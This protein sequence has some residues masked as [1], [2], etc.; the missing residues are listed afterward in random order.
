[1]VR[2][3]RV[4]WRLPVSTSTYRNLYPVYTPP[5]GV[6]SS[7]NHLDT[8]RPAYSQGLDARFGAHVLTEIDSTTGRKRT[9][10]PGPQLRT[11]VGAPR[12]GQIMGP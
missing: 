1:M 4:Y 2:A 8:P 11:T 10:R 3:G 7:T 12:S 6:Y 9:R 5:D